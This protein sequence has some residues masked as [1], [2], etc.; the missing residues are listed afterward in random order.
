MLKNIVITLIIL[1]AISVIMIPTIILIVDYKRASK[2]FE[3]NE[4]NNL[5]KRT[6]PMV[7]E[8]N[9]SLYEVKEM[10]ESKNNLFDNFTNHTNS[11]NCS[12]EIVNK[13]TNNPFK[14]VTKYFI[15]INEENLIK[16]KQY[17]EYVKNLK[18]YKNALPIKKIEILQYTMDL[19]P[20]YAAKDFRL[21]KKIGMK[22]YEL[23][24]KDKK[25]SF[26]YTSPKGQSSS[27]YVFTLNEYNISNLINYIEEN[28]KKQSNK[29]YQRNLMTKELRQ[30]ILER[31][32]Y[33]CQN[34]GLSKDDEPHLLLEVDHIIPVSKGGKTE[35]SNLQTLC[36]K[37]N[38]LKSDK[39]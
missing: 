5:L 29:S 28:I 38:R 11:Y 25:L 26:N 30:R 12:L 8:Y 17:E 6:N 35:E 34:C 31:D 19:V 7:E 16:L 1:L 27:N 13:A 10:L 18:K 23:Y 4:F 39:I 20:S 24:I 21:R 22:K 37:C 32:N 15:P 9:N 14:Y 33:T 36:W 2:Y 3:S